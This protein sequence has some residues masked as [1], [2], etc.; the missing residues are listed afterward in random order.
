MS[1]T[2]TVKSIAKELNISFSTVAKALN[3]NPKIK[4][5]TRELVINK[6]REMGYHGNF[7]AKN[8]RN[9]ASKTVAILVNDFDIPAYGDM[10][11]QISKELLS[12]GFVTVVCNSQY[13]EEIE[14]A[15]L[16]NI[17]STMPTALIVSPINPAHEN[18][19]LLSGVLDRTVMIAQ[20]IPGLETNY[21]SIDHTQS[22]YLSASHMLAKSRDNL[23][24]LGP[25]AFQASQNFLKGA[26]KAYKENKMTIE[27][28]NIFHFRPDA[29]KA[30]NLFIELYN[31]GRKPGGVICFCDSTAFGIYKAAQ[32]LGLKI[33]QDLKVIGYDDGFADDFANPP[34]TTIHV[35]KEEIAKYC[36]EKILKMRNSE[37]K[38][39]TCKIL[40]SSLIIRKSV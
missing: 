4:E 28:N 36:T 3:N 8:L 11:N 2:V 37:D 24:F 23:L 14:K 6:A 5:S 25:S 30:C 9:K 19:K 13:D 20:P 27:K 22:G 38:N 7:M 35:P 15:S 40:E 32:K 39:L 18:I 12:A 29:E 17:L 1:E 33:P 16:E 31:S 34:L 10:I 26:Q 21:V